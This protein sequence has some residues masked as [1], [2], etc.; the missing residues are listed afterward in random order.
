MPNVLAIVQE[1]AKM[2]LRQRRHRHGIRP[3][4]FI[5]GGYVRDRLLGREPLDADVEVYGLSYA[6]LH[7]LITTQFEDARVHQLPEFGMWHV[8]G[9]EYQITYSL[10]R[11]ERPTGPRHTDFAI[12]LNPKLSKR[13]AAQRRDFTC[14]ALLQLPFS[15]K[16]LDVTG[17]IKDIE[18]KLLRAVNP[19]LFPTDALRAWRAIQLAGRLGFTIER[20]T[21]RL[22]RRMTK[23]EGMAKLSGPRVREELDKLLAYGTPSTGL[24]LASRLGLIRINAP[25]LE[26]FSDMRV[27]VKT[28]D[29][30]RAS[31]PTAQ[32]RERWA[33][34]LKALTPNARQALSA[35][36]QIPKSY[37]TKI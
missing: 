9:P 18:R 8:S 32:Q 26:S 29:S 3:R 4:S 14:N 23:T 31:S 17:G 24:A 11:T 19:E 5:V 33:Y 1:F 28:L 13:Q 20:N 27:R 34:I 30:I 2:I 15:G 12:S 36:L 37:A 22:I 25:E 16:I 6:Q 21:E 35:R 10:P 7:R